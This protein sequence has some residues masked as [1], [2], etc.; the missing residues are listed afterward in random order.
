MGAARKQN[1]AAITPSPAST[2]GR[3]FSWP[4]PKPQPSP[5]AA[6]QAGLRREGGGLRA[7]LDAGARSAAAALKHVAKPRPRVSF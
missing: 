3:P 6:L 1:D 5:A 2:S 7:G 4:W